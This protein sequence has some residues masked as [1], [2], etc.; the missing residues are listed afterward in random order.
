MC[1]H[2]HTP[3]VNTFLR[4]IRTFVLYHIQIN[5]FAAG[6]YKKFYWSYQYMLHVSV[7]LVFFRHLNT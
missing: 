3:D 4:K 6:K 1:V 2:V 7:V 5:I